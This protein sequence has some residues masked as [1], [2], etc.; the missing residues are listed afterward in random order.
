MQ[1]T[2][3]PLFEINDCHWLARNILTI[4]MIQYDIM[5]ERMQCVN[6]I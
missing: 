5:D 1:G 3:G 6:V 4:S 2:I